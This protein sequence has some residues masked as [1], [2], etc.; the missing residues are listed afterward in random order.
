MKLLVTGGKGMLGRTL[1]NEFADCDIAV[2]DLPEAD[3]TD[4]AGFDAFLAQRKP[5]AV[6]HCA[7]MTA[8]DRC[9]SEIEL[10]YRL[11]AFGTAN[12]AAACNRHGVR[13][14][15]IST[16]YVFDGE[17]DRP[18]N[19][20]DRATGGN[21]V[22]GK[23]KFA[24][25]EAVRALCPDHVICRISWLYGHG[26]PSFVHAMMSLADGT[27]PL[28][29]V[30]ADQHGNP[31]SAVA[32]ARR[33]RDILSNP[34]LVGTFHL[35]CEGEATWFEFAQEIFRLAGKNQAVS[36]CTTDEF[37]RPAPRPKNS[38]LDKMMLRLAGLP[39]MPGWRDALAEFM[40][41]EFPG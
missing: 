40:K 33:L 29:K 24:G 18:Y 21:T 13:L 3:I 26:G 6:I 32:V 37:P 4:A 1:Q 10:A 19:E 2:A 34:R 14:I 38:R 30:V 7:A 9:E 12:V 8:V 20:F 39:P 5:D 31:T 22:Y 41:A 17:S 35:T 23:S 25:E 28:L 15:A 16:D 36:P 27:R 11:N